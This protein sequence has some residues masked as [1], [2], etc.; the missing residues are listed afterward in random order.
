MACPN[1]EDESAFIN[2]VESADNYTINGNILQL[3]KAKMAPLLTFEAVKNKAD[4]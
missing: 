1:M 4:K 2:A 3:N